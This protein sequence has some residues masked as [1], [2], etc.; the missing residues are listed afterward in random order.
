[1][2]DVASILDKPTDF[3]RSEAHEKWMLSLNTGNHEED[4]IP[5][6]VVIDGAE[7]PY[8]S[9]CDAG[10]SEPWDGALKLWPDYQKVGTG[11]LRGWKRR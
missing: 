2:A 4:Y 11:T 9:C 1:M 8:T 10:R 5:N 3:W 7:I 6:A